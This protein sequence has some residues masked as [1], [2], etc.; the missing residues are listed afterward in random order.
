[1]WCVNS[2]MLFILTENK[3][4][5]SLRTQ[6]FLIMRHINFASKNMQHTA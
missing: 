3:F 4:I 5:C 2:I 6:E 1:M